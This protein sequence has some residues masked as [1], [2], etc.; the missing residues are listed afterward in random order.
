VY[1]TVD[2]AASDYNVASQAVCQT[3][4]QDNHVELVLSNLW[5]NPTLTSCLL[6]AGVPQF[7][8]T[9]EVLN[10]SQMLA[11]TPNLFVPAGLTTD[12]ESAALINESVRQGWLTPKEKLGIQ[13]DSCPYDTAAV[14]GTIKPS[15]RSTAAP[16]SPTSENSPPEPRTLS[17]KCTATT[18]PG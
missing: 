11:Q 2:G 12:R 10:S 13:Y 1:A 18:S 4:T 16:A 7:E 6:S 5:V 15:K 17:C 14:N 9:S 3:L 8:G